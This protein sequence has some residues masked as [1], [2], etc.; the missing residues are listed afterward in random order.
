MIECGWCGKGIIGEP[1][2]TINNSAMV[3]NKGEIEIELMPGYEVNFCCHGCAWAF[4]AETHRLM[5]LSGDELRRHM[6]N[7][8]GFHYPPGKPAGSMKIDCMV[9]VMAERLEYV[10]G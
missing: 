8:H 9:K 2:L 7:E 1:I 6:I 5:G 10:F 4:V 3:M